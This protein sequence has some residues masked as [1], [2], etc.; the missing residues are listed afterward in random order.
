MVEKLKIYS[1]FEALNE[2]VIHCF[3]CPRLVAH[4]ETVPCP[5]IYNNKRQW[6]KPVPGFGDPKAW[7]LILGLAPSSVG[8]NRTG[9]IFTGDQSAKFLIKCLHKT[10]FANQATSV[11]IDD[12]LEFKGCYITASVKCVPPKHKPQPNEFLNC[13][14]FFFNEIYLLK[15]LKAILTLGKL[16][17]DAYK[18]Y[19]KSLGIQTKELIFK[20]NISYKIPQM[21][22][23]Y[24]SYHPSPQNT[25]TGVL[26]E[27]MFCNLLEN[28]RCE[29]SEG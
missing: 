3:R 29:M 14:S 11:S 25:N 15:N 19:L 10:N 28:I 4:R 9:R 7:L 13:S 21:P 12:G 1:T 6:R 27:T 20:N 5:S 17:F 8:G 2:N 22:T 18:G 23:F 24:A 26:T 16:S